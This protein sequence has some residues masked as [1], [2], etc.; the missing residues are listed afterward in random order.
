ME[1]KE[2]NNFFAVPLIG[3]ILCIYGI[4]GYNLFIIPSLLPGSVSFNPPGFPFI[5]V[6]IIGLVPII[7]NL[8]VGI[9]MIVS[10]V[11]LKNGKATLF[12]EKKKL[13][14][15]SWLVVSVSLGLSIFSIFG[16][17]TFLFFHEPALGAG[18]IIILGNLF[19]KRLNKGNSLFGPPL[20]QEG[21]ET[22]PSE[23]IDQSPIIVHA[24]CSNCGFKSGEESLKFCPKCGNRLDAKEELS[25]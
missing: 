10:A 20:V 11:K 8:V 18:L 16:Y 12:E 6:L 19:Y 3:G 14:T 7:L 13:L 21:E 25:V 2:R 22:E 17:G 4:F 15:Y 5:I 23:M 1:K 9:L 24:I